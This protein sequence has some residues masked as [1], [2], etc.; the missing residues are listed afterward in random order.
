MKSAFIVKLQT[1]SLQNV[2]KTT[3]FTGIF[4]EFSSQIHLAALIRTPFF[5]TL[6]NG[7][8]W[9]QKSKHEHKKIRVIHLYCWLKNRHHEILYSLSVSLHILNQLWLTR[10]LITYDISTNAMNSH[11]SYKENSLIVLSRSLF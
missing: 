9:K 1:I 2:L 7:C 10:G 11:N 8:F 5:T 6:F 4:Q 3:F